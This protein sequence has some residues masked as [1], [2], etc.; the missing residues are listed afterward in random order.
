MHTSTIGCL[1]ITT[2]G[3]DTRPL[4][5]TRLGTTSASHT[6]GKVLL[7]MPINRVSWDIATANS[8]SKCVSIMPRTGSW[9]GSLARSHQLVSTTISLAISR[10]KSTMAMEILLPRL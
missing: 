9:V 7:S 2:I 1:S 6:Q 3:A 5:F 10:G 8:I 4:N